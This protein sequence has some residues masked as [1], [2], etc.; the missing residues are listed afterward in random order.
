[1]YDHVLFPTD[2]SDGADAALAYA[3]DLAATYDATVHV[4]YVVNTNYEGTTSVGGEIV[5][6]LGR[7]GQSI[8]EEATD[9]VE[10][11]G[12][13]AIGQVLRGDP[14]GTIL[15]YAED[16]RVDLVV[17]AT[18]GR[19]GLERYLLG[20]ITE[21]VVRSAEMPVLTVRMDESE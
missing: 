14:H 11:R 12:V 2:G 10:G 21:K 17:M 15:E 4:L 6:T 13:D 19:R 1:M 9:R 5:D 20:S 8:V 18:H 3:L 7:E 16:N